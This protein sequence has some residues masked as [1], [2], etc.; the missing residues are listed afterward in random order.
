MKQNPVVE[1]NKCRGK[2]SYLCSFSCHAFYP[3]IMSSTK[4]SVGIWEDYFFGNCLFSMVVIRSFCMHLNCI[5]NNSI[6]D[7][8]LLVYDI[9]I[10]KMFFNIVQQELS[11]ETS[12]REA[13]GGF[14]WFKFLLFLRAALMQ[15]WASYST[16]PLN[17]HLSSGDKTLLCLTGIWL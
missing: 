7:M 1:G 13:S 12:K 16:L 15:D 2:K 17:F 8:F 10:E 3:K 11:S 14:G 5:L 4:K 6:I 9:I